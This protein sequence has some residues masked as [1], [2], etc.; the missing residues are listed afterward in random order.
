[1]DTQ[2]FIET[3]KRMRKFQKAYFQKRYRSDL[4]TSKRLEKEV[5]DMIAEHENPQIKLL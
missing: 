2:K 4:E 5:D 1:M 3:V